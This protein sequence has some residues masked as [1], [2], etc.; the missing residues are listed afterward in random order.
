MELYILLG[1]F[2]FGGRLGRG[3]LWRKRRHC[4][5]RLSLLAGSFVN[6][7][8]VTHFAI[9]ITAVLFFFLFLAVRGQLCWCIVVICLFHVLHT[10]GAFWEVTL[11]MP[12]FVTPE[13][14]FLRFLIRAVAAK[15]VCSITIWTARYTSLE[16]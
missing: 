15:V 13:A 11:E 5:F 14:Q 4:V 9:G 2:L 1:W 6:T 7:L 16:H 10:G 12:W 3:V 8:G